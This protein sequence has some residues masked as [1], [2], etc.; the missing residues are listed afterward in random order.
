MLLRGGDYYLPIRPSNEQTI[1]QP[2][3]FANQPDQHSKAGPF[4]VL[5]TDTLSYVVPCQSPVP[6]CIAQVLCS[7][8]CR[9]GPLS[10]VVPCQSPVV[11]CQSPVLC[12]VVP[13]SCVVQYQSPVVSCKSP[14]LCC[15]LHVPCPVLYYSTPC[16]P[17]KSPVLCCIVSPIFLPCTHLC[18]IDPAQYTVVTTTYVEYHVWDLNHSTVLTLSSS[19]CFSD[20][21]CSSRLCYCNRCSHFSCCMC[22][23]FVFALS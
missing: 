23:S 18:M 5:C 22:C 2:S 3:I 21:S 13:V 9:A 19:S 12:C 10:C 6:C 7:V 8:L 15:V 17:R 4:V 11:S 16:L 14:V 1:T 20:F